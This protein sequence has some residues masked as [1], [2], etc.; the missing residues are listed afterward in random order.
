MSK[1]K[2]PIRE[3]GKVVKIYECNDF[4][5]SLG[6]LEDLLALGEMAGKQEEV[7]KQEE[8]AI[9]MRLARPLLEEMFPDIK[10]EHIRRVRMSDI[11]QILIDAGTYA[12]KEIGQDD[13]KNG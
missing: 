11:T 1:F 7:S 2:L 13:E 4:D 12:K 5:A 8:A 10:E 3:K 9:L 6:V